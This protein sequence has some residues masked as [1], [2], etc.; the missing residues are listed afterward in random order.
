MKKNLLFLLCTLLPLASQA[1]SLTAIPR[2]DV[3]R[4]LG[5]WYEIA[6]YPNWF[7]RHCVA[8][9][10]AQYDLNSDHQLSVL[11]RCRNSKGEIEQA[12]GIARQ[13]GG[14]DS[15]R[16]EVSFAPTWLQIAPLVW[17]DYW[18]IDLDAK[19]Q[20]AAV[21]EPTRKYLW[22]L[23]RTPQVKPSAYQSLLARLEVMGFDTSGL[24]LTP[25]TGMTADQPN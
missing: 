8:D 20:L 10:T 4:Y 9:T 6:K 13:L 24:T 21:S 16:L 2:L 15:A 12:S 11:N 1:D 23:S 3:N 19:Y 7:Q 22:I 18:V 25:Q 5:T 17:G 14:P